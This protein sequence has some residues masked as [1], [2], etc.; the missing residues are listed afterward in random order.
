MAVAE[1]EAADSLLERARGGDSAALGELWQ[2]YQPH[3]LR[4]ARGCTGSDPEDLV[5]ETWVGFMSALQS[6][7][8]PTCGAATWAYLK[9]SAR[10]AAAKESRRR[11]RMTAMPEED[12][13]AAMVPMPNPA[14][15][16]DRDAIRVAQAALP[17]ETR[18]LLHMVVE[19]GLAHKEIAAK[20]SIKVGTVN[21]QVQRAYD[22]L[23]R[24]YLAQEI[25]APAT[26]LCRAI[27]AKLPGYIRGKVRAGVRE[28]IDS[29]RAE[30][31]VCDK[32]ARHLVA[33]NRH[34]R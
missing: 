20:L 30:C 27:H 3:L 7:H 11:G 26:E 1:F 15:L 10:N 31:R 24:E 13:Q 5:S 4:V 16:T 2:L 29:H 33:I 6:G 19:E 21:S 8:G 9:T 14:D 18:E 34:L 32:T 23:I 28:G 17:R 25:N 22:A 12:I